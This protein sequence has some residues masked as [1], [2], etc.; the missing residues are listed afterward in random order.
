MFG[1]AECVTLSLTTIEFLPGIQI[2]HFI[3]RKN[4]DEKI[5]TAD[6]CRIYNDVFRKER[7][8]NQLL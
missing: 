5:T 3:P 2:S 6:M 4:Y 8:S 7:E 1:K